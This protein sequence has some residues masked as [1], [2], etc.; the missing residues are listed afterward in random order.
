MALCSNIDEDM[1]TT[2]RSLLIQIGARDCEPHI[3][4]GH[5][6]CNKPPLFPSNHNELE[7]MT[8]QVQWK[9]LW[10]KVGGMTRT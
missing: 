7:A 2:E 3:L 9:Q 1:D 10:K 5:A 6:Q 8:E 4:D